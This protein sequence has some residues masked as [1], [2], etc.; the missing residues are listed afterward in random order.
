MGRSSH[1]TGVLRKGSD[2]GG[3]PEDLGPVADLLYAEPPLSPPSV[4][5]SAARDWAGIMKL[6]VALLTDAMG[7]LAGRLAHLGRSSD[8]ADAHRW[9][10]DGDCGSITF[11]TACFVVGLDP[12]S[13]RRALLNPKRSKVARWRAHRSART[14]INGKG[15]RG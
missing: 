13:A 15:K 6:H 14:R 11:R 3:I 7:L 1:A 10:A 8:V 4:P 5:P 9:I 12:S 2:S